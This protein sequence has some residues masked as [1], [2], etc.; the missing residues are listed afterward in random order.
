M[1]IIGLTGQTGAGKSTVS[2]I[3]KKYMKTTVKS[4]TGTAAQLSSLEVGGK[5][6]TAEVTVNGENLSHA[7]FT[8]FIDSDDHPLAVCVVVEFGGSGGR[9]AAPIAH[10]LLQRAVKLGY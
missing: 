6:G 4:G 2:E 8:G 3:L 5:T 10:D 1:M 9:V 7:W